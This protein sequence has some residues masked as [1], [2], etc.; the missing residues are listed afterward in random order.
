MPAGS[1]IKADMMSF[2]LY[3]GHACQIPIALLISSQLSDRRYTSSIYDEIL[4][5]KSATLTVPLIFQAWTDMLF[6]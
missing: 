4:H 2:C 6:P 1:I 5:D 3:Q